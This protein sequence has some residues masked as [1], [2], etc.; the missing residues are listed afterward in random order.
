MSNDPGKAPNDTAATQPLMEE[1]LVAPVQKK[2]STP[3]APAKA[4]IPKLSQQPWLI[5]LLSSMSVRYKIAGT[6][7][8][9]L[10]LTVATLG[11]VTF[12]Q[13][14]A[15]LRHEL[16][17]R[18]AILAQQLANIGKEG[19]LTKQEMPVFSAIMD[20]KRRDDV[21]YAMVMDYEGKVFV[22]SDLTKKGSVLRGPADQAAM[23]ADTLL[24]QET[25]SGNDPIL[26]APEP[27][28]PSY[29]RF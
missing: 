1:Q 8:M 19:L 11:V 20:I 2:A 29:W 5:R 27:Q 21:V 25:G 6:L 10:S 4:E 28:Q 17:T 26:D 16:K 9:I 23:K 24:F 15:S 18:A 13:Q 22:H 3:P 7:I 14:N 12:T